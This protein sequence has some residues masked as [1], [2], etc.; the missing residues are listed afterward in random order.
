MTV[1]SLIYAINI[2][3]TIKH[4]NRTRETSNQLLL[5]TN[6]NSQLYM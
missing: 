4:Q 6:S 1:F 5:L 3:C 2:N